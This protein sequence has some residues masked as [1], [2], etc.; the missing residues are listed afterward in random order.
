MGDA[1]RSPATTDLEITDRRSGRSQKRPTRIVGEDDPGEL[2]DRL[3][4]R[5]DRA[6]GINR[7]PIATDHGFNET[8]VIED[9]A[10]VD[11]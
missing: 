3:D 6:H 10:Q 2:G 5:N 9:P 1:G 4:S 7:V 11:A 8:I